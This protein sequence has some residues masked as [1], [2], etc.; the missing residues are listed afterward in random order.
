MLIGG[1]SRIAEFRETSARRRRHI[2]PKNDKLAEP[3]RPAKRLGA[4]RTRGAFDGIFTGTVTEAESLCFY[5]NWFPNLR[6]RAG[7]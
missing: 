5:N 7:C 2:T 4:R 1:D 3:W 6:L